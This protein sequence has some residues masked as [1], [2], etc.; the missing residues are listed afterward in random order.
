MKDIHRTELKQGI[1][2]FETAM[3]ANRLDGK[4]PTFSRSRGKAISRINSCIMAFDKYC[5]SINELYSS[6][7]IYMHSASGLFDQVED[8]NTRKN[9]GLK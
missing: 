7:S 9:E 5:D 4:T 6:T 8:D 3:S 1:A 2:D